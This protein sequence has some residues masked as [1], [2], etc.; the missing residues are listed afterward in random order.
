MRRSAL[1]C[2]LV[3]A[4]CLL[5]ACAG[6]S[7]AT[8]TDTSRA[9]ATTPGATPG[10]VAPGTGV[11]AAPGPVTFAF[12][13]DTQ[14]GDLQDSEAGATSTGLPVLAD[15]VKTDP[16]AVLTAIAP[17]LSG[18]DLAMVNLETSVTEA[19][20][21]VPDKTFHFRSPAASF[22]ALRAAGVDIA[23]MANNH[24]LDYGPAGLQDTFAAISAAHFPVLGIG[25]DAAEAF[26][27]YRATIRGQRV[28]ILTAV[29]WLEPALIPQWT[30]TD[31]RAG[32]AGA[33]DPTRLVAAVRALRPQV[34]TLVV[35]MHW[36]TEQDLCADAGQRSLE[37]LLAS[38]GADIIVGAHAHRVQGAGHIG[39][40]FVAYGLGNFTWWREDGENG[41]TGVLRVTATGRHVDSYS[42][43]PARIRSGVPVP[44]TGAAATADVNEWQRRRQCSGLSP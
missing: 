7:R 26:H 29:D 37:R 5:A 23:T 28:G 2:F 44:L 40:T 8:G 20:Q 19:G 11:A 34:D 41:R 12:A 43:V 38:A 13:G 18:A 22:D 42:W 10:H 4:C 33:F 3:L 39:N 31:S 6:G 35:F 9:P 36:G 21:A 1:A 17:T 15:R 24:A 30:A 25:H 27:P 14:F 16:S 32:L